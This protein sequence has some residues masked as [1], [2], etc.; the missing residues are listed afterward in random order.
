MRTLIVVASR[1]GGSTGIAEALADEIRATGQ[2]VDVCA[3][4]DAPAVDGYDAL[5]VGS[6][7]YMGRWLPQARE[8]VK[9]H[10]QQL[11]SIPVWLFSS[12]PIGAREPQSKD[13]PTEVEKLIQQTAARGHHMFTGKLDRA[14]LGN[15]ER[16]I[17]WNVNRLTPG[18][19]PDGDFRNW[20]AIRAWAREIA[21]S[22]S[23]VAVSAT[24]RDREPAWQIPRSKA[25][26][27]G[28]SPA[29][30]CGAPEGRQKEDA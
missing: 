14:H 4:G 22:V 18:G 27:T 1:H 24:A 3:P 13:E 30:R 16:F 7:V 11:A 25:V 9:Q 21:V 28:T 12:G 6:A 2:I 19:I 20:E 26:A 17:I 23:A 10:Q 8:F 15:V 29:G 5:V